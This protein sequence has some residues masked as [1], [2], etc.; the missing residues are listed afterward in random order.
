MVTYGLVGCDEKFAFFIKT[1]TVG[2]QRQPPPNKRQ[3]C[4]LEKCQCITTIFWLRCVMK[5][6]FI[7]NHKVITK[8]ALKYIGN[9]FVVINTHAVLGGN[10]ATAPLKLEVA[11]SKTYE[12]SIGVVIERS[13]WVTQYTDRSTDPTRV[14][15]LTGQ[16]PSYRPCTSSFEVSS[17]Y[18]LFEMEV[19]LIVQRRDLSMVEQPIVA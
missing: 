19:P 9:L 11:H 10:T 13:R 17:N 14:T 5:I 18:G 8:N 15:R 4:T 16:Q 1:A 7:L 6:Y 12:L 2:R 3:V